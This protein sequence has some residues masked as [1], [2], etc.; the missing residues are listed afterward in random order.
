M[1]KLLLFTFLLSISGNFANAYADD[2]NGS[3]KVYGDASAASNFQPRTDLSTSERLAVLERQVSYLNQ[4]NSSSK[5]EDLQ[6]QIASLQGRIDTLEHANQQLQDQLKQQY[7]DLDQ[8]LTQKTTAPAA[9]VTADKKASVKLEDNENALA[10]GDT[11]ASSTN[12]AAEQAAYQ[13]AFTLLKKKDYVRALPAFQNLLSKYPHGSF[14]PNAYF[15]MAEICLVQGQPDDAATNYRKVITDFPSSDKV[16]MAQLKLGFA[17]RDSGNAAKSR[18]QFQKVI[19][20]Y[21]NTQAGKLAAKQ[22]AQTK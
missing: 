7:Q 13:K 14:A 17:Y 9:A 22:L 16:Q 12:S 11:Q 4:K 3:D 18:A 5:L 19:K 15:W 21:P 2:N 20:L 1:K 10:D 6:S 8:R